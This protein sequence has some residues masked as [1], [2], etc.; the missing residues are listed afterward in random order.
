MTLKNAVKDVVGVQ[1]RN[2]A[3]NRR[4][5]LGDALIFRCADC[6][7]A[8][9]SYVS[10][11]RAELFQWQIFVSMKMDNDIFDSCDCK[12]ACLSDRIYGC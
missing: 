3:I 4:K 5:H 6:F 1:F 10:F 7:S 8:M 2:M 9:D 11:I 12:K